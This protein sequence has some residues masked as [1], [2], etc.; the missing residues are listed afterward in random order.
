MRLPCLFLSA[1]VKSHLTLLVAAKNRLAFK[2]LAPAKLSAFN[3]IRKK[4]AENGTHIEKN[5]PFFC[6]LQQKIDTS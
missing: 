6:L 4:T 1:T 3:K 2:I 5:P